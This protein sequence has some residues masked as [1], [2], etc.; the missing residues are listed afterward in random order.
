MSVHSADC[1]GPPHVCCCVCSSAGINVSACDVAGGEGGSEGLTLIC[2]G[3]CP[4]PRSS[5]AKYNGRDFWGVLELC[6]CHVVVDCLQTLRLGSSSESESSS[7]R[8]LV[9]MV[10]N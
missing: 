9:G 6:C 2:N 10:W 7:R 4:N 1:T 5:C 8:R 3:D